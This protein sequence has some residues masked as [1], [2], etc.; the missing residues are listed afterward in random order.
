MKAPASFSPPLFPASA[1]PAESC[2]ERRLS[3]LKMDLN[4]FEEDGEVGE[5]GEVGEAG[6]VRSAEVRSRSFDTC[7]AGVGSSYRSS[8]SSAIALSAVRGSLGR[9]LDLRFSS[10]ASR[11]SSAFF[12][13]SAS[14]SCFAAAFS[15]AIR[16]FEIR[17]SSSMTH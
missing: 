3:L 16:A 2:L 7:P 4:P 11:C 8:F 13:L 15:S 1:V 9:S 10:F 17:F 14:F 6:E 12:V 5:V